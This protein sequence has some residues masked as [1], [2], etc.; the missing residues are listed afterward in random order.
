MALTNVAKP[1]TVIAN[2]DRIDIAETWATITSTWASETRTW[3]DMASLIDNISKQT[4][5]ITNVAKPA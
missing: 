2:S 5:S 1:T 3:E 4:P